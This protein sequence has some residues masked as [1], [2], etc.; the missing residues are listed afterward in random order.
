M[1]GVAVE[2]TECNYNWSGERSRMLH[3]SDG[4]LFMERSERVEDHA[5]TELQQSG[6]VQA[7]DVIRVQLN[8][9]ELS[10]ISFERKATRKESDLDPA[11]KRAGASRSC[12]RFVLFN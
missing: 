1:V 6:G 12:C 11:G 5:I 9:D 10:A 4:R 2:F 7:G 3:L 8:M